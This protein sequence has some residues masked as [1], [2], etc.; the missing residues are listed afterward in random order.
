M[1]R[2]KTVMVTGAYG[3]VGRAIVAEL[4]RR[5]FDSVVALNSK[6]HD[7]RDYAETDQA[8]RQHRPDYVFHCAAKVGGIMGHVG[9]PV[10]FFRDNTLMQLNVLDAA[11]RWGVEKLLFLASACAYPKHAPTPVR[12]DS[13][14]TGPLE[15]S[16][17]LYALAKISGVKLCDAYRRQHNCNFIS[18]MPTNMYGIGDTYHPQN[19]H[20]IPGMI[21]KFHDAFIKSAPK[22]TLW[23]SG[24]PKRDFL[25]AADAASAFFLLMEKWNSPGVVN[26]CSGES[27][28]LWQLAD[29]VR[30]T[31]VFNGEI[32]WDCSKPDGTP[33]RTMS[34]DILRGLGWRPEISLGAGLEVAYADFLR[35]VL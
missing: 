27:V 18:A 13:L 12:E 30:A 28:F 17:E 9:A 2:N 15:P 1:D 35:R 20:V 4:Y 34:C 5:G 32:E 31:V 11:R 8:F 33:D 3:M 23:G 6:S 29:E 7:L 19:S 22:V 16:N 14:L 25:N 10:E 24:T 21:R 26:V